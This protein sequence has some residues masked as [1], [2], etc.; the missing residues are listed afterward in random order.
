MAST[1]CGTLTF[2]F[3]CGLREYHEYRCMWSSEL[4][5]V[6]PA[7]HEKNNPHDRY[8]KSLEKFIGSRTEN[9]MIVRGVVTCTGLYS[10]SWTSFTFSVHNIYRFTRHFQKTCTIEGVT[11]LEDSQVAIPAYTLH[12]SPE[13]REVLCPL[14][15]IITIFR[16]MQYTVRIR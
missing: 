2:S 16:A 10:C 12:H 1:D 9:I 3:F 13:Y 8:A 5:K 15:G 14:Y 6:P 7:K 11:I 4:N